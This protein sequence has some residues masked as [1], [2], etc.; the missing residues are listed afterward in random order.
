[1]QAQNL[2]GFSFSDQGLV[3]IMVEEKKSYLKARISNG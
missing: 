3:A 1:M 2:H